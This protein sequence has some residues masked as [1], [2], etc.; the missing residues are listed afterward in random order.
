MINTN[1][2]SVKTYLNVLKTLRTTLLSL[3]WVKME[4]KKTFCFLWSIYLRSILSWHTLTIWISE[5]RQHIIWTILW[6]LWLLY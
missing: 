2:S 1:T 4:L 5:M 3:L 6:D